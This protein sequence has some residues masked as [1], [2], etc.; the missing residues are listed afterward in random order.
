MSLINSKFYEK[1]HK[2]YA[3]KPTIVKFSDDN[4]RRNN[5]RRS[6]RARASNKEYNRKPMNWCEG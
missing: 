2:A 1:F 5:Y 3:P 6:I 4:W